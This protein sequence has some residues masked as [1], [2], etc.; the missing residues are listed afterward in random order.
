MKLEATPGSDKQ[1]IREAIDELTAGGSTAG[2]AGILLAYKIAKKNL[3]LMVTTVSYFA[4][5]VIL[6]WVFLPPKDWNN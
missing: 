3:S 1:K 6:M 5:T 4:P 2:G